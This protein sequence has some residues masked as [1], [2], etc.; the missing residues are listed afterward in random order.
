MA[1]VTLFACAKRC[2][3]ASLRSAAMR[4]SRLLR[5]IKIGGKVENNTN[6]RINEI[7]ITKTDNK[8][9]YVRIYCKIEYNGNIKYKSYTVGGITKDYIG[10]DDYEV[11]VEVKN[12]YKDTVLL[13]LIADRFNSESE[14]MNWLG[15]QKI[16]YSFISWP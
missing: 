1:I 2:A 13:K 7:E 14:F 5:G 4:L 10:H 8:E 16:P 3:N 9:V 15:E 11:E 6:A 12:E